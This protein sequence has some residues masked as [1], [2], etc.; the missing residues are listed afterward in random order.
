MH[1]QTDE[2]LTKM[3]DEGLSH[4]Y[5]DELPTEMLPAV[6]RYVVDGLPP[7]DFLEAVITNN[8]RHALVCADERNL[9][10][11]PVWVRFFYNCVPSGCYGDERDMRAWMG[12]RRKNTNKNGT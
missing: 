5:Y 12:E 11:L 8:L 10:V 9:K 4:S 1:I 3:L 7:G 2:E 6:Y